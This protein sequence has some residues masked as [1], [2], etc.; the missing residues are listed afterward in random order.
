MTVLRTGCWMIS[1][2][3]SALSPI[4][5]RSF[6]VTGR[7]ALYNTPCD[8]EQNI[9]MSPRILPTSLMPW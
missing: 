9:A 5:D 2:T 1:G 3:G 8:R 7:C 4:T 6:K